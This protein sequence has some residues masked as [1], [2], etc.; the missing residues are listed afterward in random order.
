[1][2]HGGTAIG[3]VTSA[4]NYTSNGAGACCR[5]RCVYALAARQNSISPH[6]AYVG[7]ETGLAQRT[8][9]FFATPALR[10]P[11]RPFAPRPICFAIAERFSEY[12]GATIGYEFGSSNRCL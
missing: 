10:P 3:R 6:G 9:A 7:T 1:M 12:D 4:N 2:R 5:N 11:P 8:E